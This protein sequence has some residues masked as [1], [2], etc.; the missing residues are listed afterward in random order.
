MR[1]RWRKE[2]TLQRLAVSD[3]PPTT[4]ERCPISVSTIKPDYYSSIVLVD[5]VW[6]RIDVIDFVEGAD[7]GFSEGNVIKY[8]VRAGKKPGV[9]ALSDLYKAQEYIRRLITYAEAE[10]DT[11]EGGYP[12]WEDKASRYDT[13]ILDSA[14]AEVEARTVENFAQAGALYT[15]KML[16]ADMDDDEPTVSDEDEDE[17]D[18][19]SSAGDLLLDDDEGSF[20]VGGDDLQPEEQVELEMANPTSAEFV[21]PETSPR[22]LSLSERIRAR[23]AA[24][25]TSEGPRLVTAPAPVEDEAPVSSAHPLAWASKLG[26][27]VDQPGSFPT[28]K[29]ALAKGGWGIIEDI[30]GLVSAEDDYYVICPDG[31]TRYLSVEYAAGLIKNPAGHFILDA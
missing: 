2:S 14:Q 10:A 16:D 25:D 24:P 13:S 15:Q 5:G 22:P 29:D 19:P 4:N 23:T 6:T 31:S 18:E 12:G 17:D 1:K 27:L 8:T 20:G 30:E 26:S 28:T 21:I 11:R 7:V 9:E 3:R